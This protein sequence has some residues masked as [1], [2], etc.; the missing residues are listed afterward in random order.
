MKAKAWGA[1]I[2]ALVLLVAYVQIR[3]WLHHALP[4]GVPGWVKP[5]ALALPAALFVAYV[6]FRVVATRRLL[7]TRVCYAAIPTESFDP[8]ADDVAA[9][10]RALRGLRKIVLNWLDWNAAAFRILYVQAGAGTLGVLWEVPRRSVSAMIAAAN[11]LGPEVEIR[12][13][14]SVD[15]CVPALQAFRRPCPNG[16][17]EL[18]LELRLARPG[19]FPLKAVALDPHPTQV[20]AAAFRC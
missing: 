6:A 20:F 3:A 4:H 2:A 1:V 10:G 13:A 16:V 17:H 14:D 8:S 15:V 5:L 7:A 18:R 11:A 12:P 19:C 9:F